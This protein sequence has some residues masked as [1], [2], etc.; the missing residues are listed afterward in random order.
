VVAGTQNKKDPPQKSKLSSQ[1]N[2]VIAFTPAPGS[3]K[4]HIHQNVSLQQW[5]KFIILHRIGK[6]MMEATAEVW[7]MLQ[8]HVYIRSRNTLKILQ[9]MAWGSKMGL[10]I[11]Q[12]T[13]VNYHIVRR[14]VGIFYLIL[15]IK[16]LR[17][18]ITFSFIY[19]LAAIDSP[20]FCIFCTTIS[21]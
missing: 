8:L 5:C 10:F 1:R 3:K 18:N 16:T 15:F 12:S 14:R 4:L 2:S 19:V 21:R 17:Q 20:A 7:D 13:H 11:M 9:L 6:V